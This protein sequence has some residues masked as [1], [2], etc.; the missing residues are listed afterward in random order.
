[1]KYV[2]LGAAAAVFS[3]LLT[4]AVAWLAG[5]IGAMDVPTARKRHRAPVPRIG[6]VAVALAGSLAIAAGMAADAALGT[7]P[8]VDL[9]EWIPL[10]TGGACVFAVGLGDDL[11]PL[12]PW[13]KLAGLVAAASVVT[14]L[15]VRVERVTLLGTTHELGVLAVPV[16]L[17]W[18]IVLSNAF[19]LMDGLDG[20]A[21]GLGIIAATTCG[22]LLVARGD[23]QGGMAV[24]VLLGALCGFLPYNVG[25]A[26]IFLGDS[27]S[28][29]IGYVLGVTAITG[30]Q[31]GATA[32]AVMVPL[33]IFALPIAE[34]VSSAARRF[35]ARP[36][37]APP[38]HPLMRLG[39]RLRQVV[40]ADRAHIHD[41]LA[42]SGLSPRSVVLL[43][44]AA[45]ASL[46]LLA[47]AVAR[48]P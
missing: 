31:K 9:R 37:T 10:V 33:L 32:L 28:L 40:E 17:G 38:R 8:A 16:T 12:S 39:R 25:P 44:Y 46:S 7:G 23:P 27:G 19:N 29:L 36:P 14:A 11:I 5:R 43:L 21:T 26:R 2:L 35:F 30:T 20:L 1:V 13:A 22:V 41:R 3:L 34:T 47:L 6:G 15:G 18:I 4:P 42:D 48:V 24:T 45:S